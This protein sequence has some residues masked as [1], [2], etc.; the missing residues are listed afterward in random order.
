MVRVLLSVTLL[1]YIVSALILPCEASDLIENPQY[2]SWARY[3]PG[4][5]IVWKRILTTGGMTV[6]QKETMT[7]KEVNAEKVVVESKLLS[8]V[9]DTLVPQKTETQVHSARIPL[10]TSS[11]VSIRKVGEETLTINGTKFFTTIKLSEFFIRGEKNSAKNWL[12]DEFPGGT[13]KTVYQSEGSAPM[14]MENRV[15]DFTLIK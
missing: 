9:N 8:L 1:L 11:E 14:D 4:T 13:L 3:K 6:E 10:S 2:R 15:V 5:T 7:L 12:N